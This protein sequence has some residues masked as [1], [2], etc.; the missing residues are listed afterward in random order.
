MAAASAPLMN[1][2]RGIMLKRKEN[3]SWQ[4]V[5]LSLSLDN[6]YLYSGTSFIDHK[7]TFPLQNTTFAFVEDMGKENCFQLHSDNPSFDLYFSAPSS[8]KRNEWRHE[9][10]WRLAVCEPSLLRL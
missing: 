1:G 5:G 7:A 10:T 6:I 9:F 4:P 8:E 2:I 3:G